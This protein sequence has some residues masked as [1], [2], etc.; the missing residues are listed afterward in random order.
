MNIK[1]K[2]AFYVIQEL[3]NG[4]ENCSL[5]C[6]LI[7]NG[8]EF[9]RDSN[10]AIVH[11]EESGYNQPGHAGVGYDSAVVGCNAEPCGGEP[12]C[13]R[14]CPTGALIYDTL[15][16]IV[17]K[18]QLLMEKWKTS[19]EAHVRAPWAQRRNFA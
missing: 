1:D 11:A 17:Q 18:K 14:Y 16:G 2:K 9:S 8:K 4:C 5:V 13:A 12:K 15:E 19:G 10:I 3:C 7:L 6:S